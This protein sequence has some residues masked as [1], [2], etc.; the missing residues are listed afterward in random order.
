GRGGCTGE[1]RVAAQG[2]QPRLLR[3]HSF[4]MMALLPSRSSGVLLHPS[5][6]P[7]PLGA[8][9]FG[10]AAF[11]FVDWLAEAGMGL[12]Q[13]LPLGPA[14]EGDSPYISPSAFAIDPAFIDLQA[15]RD[16]R[17]LAPDALDRE[18]L[19]AV[20]A[21]AG[22][23]AAFAANREFRMARLR[24]AAGRYFESLEPGGYESFCVAEGHWLDD[25]AR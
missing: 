15:L 13:I 3:A 20:F 21:D 11:R 19:P 12:W 4:A 25:Y 14:G 2:A 23:Q 24:E 5:S 16:Q 17:L 18:R 10:D 22:R 1:R 7:G 9:D 8:G 6:L